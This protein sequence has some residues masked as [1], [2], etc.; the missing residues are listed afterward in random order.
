MKQALVYLYR[1]RAYPTFP[2]PHIRTNAFL[3]GRELLLSLDLPHVRRKSDAMRFESGKNGLTRQLVARGLRPLLVDR[4]GKS[5]E[6]ADWDDTEIFWRGNQRDLLV[7]DN[8]TEH[9]ADLNLPMRERY[10]D[11]AWRPVR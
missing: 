9:F 7:A 1:S 5:Y 8:Q 10:T 11:Y 2:N 4:H 3:I 6:V